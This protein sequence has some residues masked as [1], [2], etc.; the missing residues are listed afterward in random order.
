MFATSVFLAQY[1]QLARGAT[2][3]ESGLMT[4]PMIVGQMGASILIGALISRF[5][6]WKGFMV[7]GALLTLAGTILM[8]TLTYDTDFALVSVYMFTLGAG[9]GMVMQNLTLVVQNDTPVS[10]LG[11]ASSNVNFFR[12]IA[13][14]IGVTIMGSQLASRVTAHTADGFADFTPT[15]PDEVEALQ[16]SLAAPCRTCT[17]CRPPSA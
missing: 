6:R 8:T 3:T 4:I 11:A 5:G 1:F 2:P 13:G 7:L 14:T 17:T 16:G 12:S 10:Q 15:T 9:L